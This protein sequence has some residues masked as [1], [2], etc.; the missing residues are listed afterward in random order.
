MT[1]LE[2]QKRKNWAL[3]VLQSCNS[4]E[5]ISRMEALARKLLGTEKQEL[6]RPNCFTLDEVKAMLKETNREKE[7]NVYVNEQELHD[8]FQSLQ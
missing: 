5:A 7:N 2:L 1:A 3:E 6:Q 8:F 4:E